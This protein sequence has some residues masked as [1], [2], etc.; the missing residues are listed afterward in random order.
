MNIKESL[1]KLKTLLG[2]DAS[3]AL[4]IISDIE[5]QNQ[6]RDRAMKSAN[7]ES[8]ER[9]IALEE[10]DAVIKSKDDE[11]AKAQSPEA[12]A[13]IAELRKIKEA[14]EALLT[15]KAAETL[16]S[17]TEK[18]KLL[19]IDKTDKRYDKV[20][21]IKGKFIMPTEGQELTPDQLAKNIETYDL[22][23]EAGYFAV[24]TQEAGGRSPLPTNTQAPAT[25]AEAYAAVIQ[26]K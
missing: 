7:K 23:T 5:R 26:R 13:E 4:S 6:D 3:D 2:A 24:E 18:A 1:D 19:S 8:E 9:R 15:A 14:H 12:K 22:L 10:K 11:I 16:A 20:E 25:R 17:W 21:K